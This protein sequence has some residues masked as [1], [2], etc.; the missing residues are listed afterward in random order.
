M[1]SQ[2]IGWE[3]FG[4]SSCKWKRPHEGCHPRCNVYSFIPPRKRSSLWHLLLSPKACTDPCACNY[5]ILYQLQYI[6]ILLHSTFKKKETEIS[7]W[8]SSLIP[9][10]GP[11]PTALQR[12]R[13]WRFWCPDAAGPHRWAAG[14]H[15][16]CGCSCSASSCPGMRCCGWTSHWL[17][18][19][20]KGWRKAVASYNLFAHSKKN[21]KS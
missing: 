1:K 19:F 8:S 12:S 13:W 5:I 21:R 18:R 7:F 17:C 4:R 2:W 9:S 6:E 16:W 15:S 20:L 14:S 11:S 3:D 10:S